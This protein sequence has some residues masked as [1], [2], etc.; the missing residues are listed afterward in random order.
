MGKQTDSQ[1]QA[2][3][4]AL[5]C[6]ADRWTLD[7][8]TRGSPKNDNNRGHR[9]VDT[10]NPPGRGASHDGGDNNHEPC[11]KIMMIMPPLQGRSVGGGRYYYIHDLRGWMRV[12]GG[13]SLVGPYD[14]FLWSTASIDGAPPSSL[15]DPDK[16]RRIARAE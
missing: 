15:L 3:D 14:R 6:I 12:G 16:K 4:P 8:V 1:Q 10:I 9:R 11:T 2:P 5:Q 7:L 13:T